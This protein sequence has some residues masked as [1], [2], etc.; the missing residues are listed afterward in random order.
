MSPTLLA[1][2]DHILDDLNW[3]A[4][5]GGAKSQRKVFRYMQQASGIRTWNYFQ[6]IHAKQH[7]FDRIAAM[8]SSFNFDQHSTHLNHEAGI[9]CLDARLRDQLEGQ[10]TLDII[11]SVPTVSLNE[12]H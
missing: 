7:L 2:F 9:L 10:V 11:N 4:N 3:N 8:V 1:I 5:K 12:D 6:F